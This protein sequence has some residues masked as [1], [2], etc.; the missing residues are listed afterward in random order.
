M[1]ACSRAVLLLAPCVL[2]IPRTA[3]D[4][5]PANAAPF[6]LPSQITEA[7]QVKHSTLFS[8]QHYSTY[9]VISFANTLLFK[10]GW[11]DA[12]MRGQ[13]IPDLVL[14]KCGT[15]RPSTV[16]NGVSEDAMFFSIPIER[17]ALAWTGVIHFFE[18]LSLSEKIN[19][20]DMT[21]ISSPCQQLLEVCNP[22]IHAPS[23]HETWDET[24]NTSTAVFTDSWGTGATN[25]FRDLPFDVSLDSGIL[26]RAEW[27]RFAALFFN[28][29]VEAGRIFTRI[30]ADYK[31]LKD[32]AARLQDERTS[33]APQVAWVTWQ[34][35]VD[36]AC[37]GITAGTWVQKGDG[38]WCRCGSFYRVLASHFRRDITEDAGGRLLTVLAAGPNCTFLTNSDG[39]QTYECIG[40]PDG[41]QHFRELLAGADVIIDE[42]YVANHGPY[43]LNDFV[44]TFE[45]EPANLL[46]MQT[47]AV[48]R[49]DG[50]VSDAR[51]DSE[52]VG[53]NW[54]EQM[55]AQPQELLSDMMRAIWGSSFQGSCPYKYLR[56][57]YGLQARDPLEHSDCPMYDPQG[58]H[59]CEAIHDYDHQ[60]HRCAFVSTSSSSESSTSS[61]SSRT[62]SDTSTSSTSS[63][64]PS[65]VSSV[66]KMMLIS[67]WVLVTVFGPH[68]FC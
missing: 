56:S 24:V 6:T 65:E 45:V 19:A 21:Y 39:S 66:K 10:S 50:S 38:N 29:E 61:G 59:D 12:S 27:I 28:L 4:P 17:A 57:L 22:S 8:V 30:E 23:W 14:Y 44:S 54:F 68:M 18:L 25:S 60:V 53:S 67:P 36:S 16:F 3:A 31:C 58:T 51:D 46:A 11:P 33:A 37:D 62:S 32:E 52:E 42:S 43:T 9:K 35:C 63:T 64:A 49:I 34:G 5:C 20:I 40:T 7:E 13:P 41:A 47:E 2:L 15:E 48:Y 55:P 1:F 26:P